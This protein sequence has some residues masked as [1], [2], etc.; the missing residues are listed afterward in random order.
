LQAARKTGRTGTPVPRIED[1]ALLSDLETAALVGVDGSIDWCCFPR[2]DSGA[3]FAALLG[4]ADHGRWSLAPDEEVRATTRAYR[5][6][7]LVLDTVFETES[8]VVCVTD[9]MPPR[10]EVP[11]IVRVV[12]GRAGRVRMQCELV[13]RFDYGHVVPWVRRDGDAL[14]AVAGPDA[15]CMRT[16]VELTGEN[17]R[18]VAE[19]EVAPG[20]EVPFVLTWFPSHRR[21]LEPLDPMEALADTES[22]W[23]DWSERCTYAGPHREAVAQS[24]R[25]LKALTYAPTGGI[26][27]APTTSLP[28]RIG[29]ERNWD[30]RYC[31]LRDAALT[32]VAMLRGGYAEEAETWRDWL[33]RAIAGSPG[34]VQIM[35][36]LAGERRLD[37]RELEWLPGYEGS[38]P[39]RI[40]NAASTQ[41]QLDVYGEVVD[42][43]LAARR[44]GAAAIDEAWDLL[45]VTLDWLEDGWRRPD[46]GI[47]EVRGPERHFTHSK[48]MAWVAF[49]RA[50]QA[51]ESF[52]REGP[53][54]RWS[55]IRDELRAEVLARAW[56]DEQQAFVQSY[57]S[58]EL[59]ASVLLMPLVGF[60]EAGD[61]RM[62]STVAAI[63]RTLL[64]DGLVLRYLPRDDGA[65]DG[66]SGD[67]GVF[68][69]CSF[70]L[71]S[72][73]ALQGRVEDAE[74]LYER[75]LALRSDVGLLAEEYDPVAGRQLGNFPQAF[76]HLEL[77]NT[78]FVL[79]GVAAATA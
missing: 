75:L 60:L 56:N 9:F 14:L 26:V 71:A 6:D 29:G 5:P 36:G 73:F 12:Q 64:R 43:M 10:N 47:W 76:T 23:R 48:V 59:D 30:Y 24:L 21:P 28:E 65:V 72:V 62:L 61:D 27:A 46:A 49:D 1:Y 7:T 20:E 4:S 32:L 66:L 77:I 15:L 34:D 54:A 44:G 70:W 55:S 37:E 35:Y 53:I 45:R 11:D 19:F 3:C 17:F 22:F 16:P 2:F 79:D 57:G 50:I 74:R 42:A 40:G 52:G 25:V 68:L 69:A 33:L 18:T 51:V 67:E 78:A 39:V 58:D 31:W 8:G 13:V 38:A 41:P 63:E